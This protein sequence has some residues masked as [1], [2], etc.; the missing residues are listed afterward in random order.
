[1]A[2]TRRRSRVG[3]AARHSSS[4]RI[5]TA[6]CE[7][8]EGLPATEWVGAMRTLVAV[9]NGRSSGG[10]PTRSAMVSM[11]PFGSATKSS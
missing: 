2:V 8:R 9:S 1:M 11:T 7:W 6:P 4:E 10:R 5:S 3:I